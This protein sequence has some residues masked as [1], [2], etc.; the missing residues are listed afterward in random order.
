MS[1]PL[2]LILIFPFVALF[3]YSV[4]AIFWTA[5]SQLKFLAFYRREGLAP[6]PM[7]GQ[8]WVRFYRRTLVG[9]LYLLWWS[10]RAAGQA[11]YH[12]PAIEPTGRPVLCVHGVFMNSTCMWGIRRSLES[13]GRGTRS[14]SLG[15]PLPT[16]LSY[17][18][19]LIRVMDDMRRQFPEQKF[20]V[21]AHS[22]GGVMLREVLHRRSDL[23]P[24]V[25]RI[26]TLG[27]P[28]R[29]TAFLRWMRFGPLYRML[30]R[31]SSYLKALP[32]FADLAPESPV[33][34]VATR[35][36]LVVY[37]VD[38]A[39]LE[40]TTQICLDQVSHLGLMV[41]PDVM[42]VIVDSLSADAGESSASRVESD[43][44]R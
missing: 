20:D 5:L 19:P 39:L 40:N 42:R 16:P 43:V 29:G 26:V 41:R 25:G 21:V 44:S 8:E 14:V 1:T 36:D 24:S 15:V 6:P 10:I 34:T 2:L 12:P 9:A 3:A 31:Q 27:T 28:H 37:P 18:G 13:E 4:G 23:I 7:T 35:H 32:T 33:T 30:N 22:L 11:K 38:M 17:A